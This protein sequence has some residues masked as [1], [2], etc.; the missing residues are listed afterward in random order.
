MKLSLSSLKPVK[1]GDG[2]L[3]IVETL[4]SLLGEARSSN[5]AKSRRQSLW[6]LY[7][8]VNIL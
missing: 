1:V 4:V 2:R 6:S 7:E 8:I 3:K 5:C